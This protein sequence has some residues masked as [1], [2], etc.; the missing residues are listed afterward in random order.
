LKFE[1]IRTIKVFDSTITERDKEGRRREGRMK[2][3]KERRK[4]E[5]E[6]EWT[7]ETLQNS[8]I[9]THITMNSIC[10]IWEPGT[11]TKSLG[12]KFHL[13]HFMNLS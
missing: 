6:E 8:L 4:E 11:K 1:T 9:R 13:Y 12:F 7:L 2:G 3:G 10:S 5:N